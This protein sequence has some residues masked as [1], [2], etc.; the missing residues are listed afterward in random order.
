MNF[1]NRRKFLSG[2]SILSASS[3]VTLPL[4]GCSPED[5]NILNTVL[6][7]AEAVLAVA[8]PGASWAASFASAVTALKNAETSWQGGSPVSIVISALNTLAAVSAAIPV[9]A[10]YSPLIDVLVAGIDAV[11]TAL[12]V[13]TAATISRVGISN[14]A[15][16]PHYG[17]ASLRKPHFLQSHVGAYKTQWNDIVNSN[18]KLSAAK[19]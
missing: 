2:V 18:P 8:E 4:T 12:P 17:R 7:S 3:L 15:G 14:A 10:V 6:A 16:N 1:I 9:T 5:V 13:S 19:I 11:L